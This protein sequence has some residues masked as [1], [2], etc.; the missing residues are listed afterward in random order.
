[1]G[2]RV[3]G[4]VGGALLLLLGTV[5]QSVWA[6]PDPPAAACTRAGAK[7]ECPDYADSIT[8]ICRVPC[9]AGGFFFQFGAACRDGAQTVDAHCSRGPDHRMQYVEGG[10]TAHMATGA[11]PGATYQAQTFQITWDC[12]T[13]PAGSSEPPARR[14]FHFSYAR[15]D[16][17]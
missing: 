10:G 3:R 6:D 13:L 12:P 17:A 7:P 14:T 5:S 11:T 1:M 4:T 16:Y 8:D 15:R 9:P 2:K